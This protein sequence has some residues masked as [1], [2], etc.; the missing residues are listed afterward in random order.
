MA[1]LLFLS[2][3]VILFYNCLFYLLGDY[4]SRFI[5]IKHKTVL[6]FFVFFLGYFLVATPISLFELSWSLFFISILLLHLVLF[7]LGLFYF[8]KNRRYQQINKQKLL[9]YVKKY[10]FVIITIIILIV[11]YL[12]SDRSLLGVAEKERFWIMDNAFYSAKAIKAI[13]SHHIGMMNPENGEMM[14]TATK[15]MIS[16]V[17]WEYLWSFVAV[18][19]GLS[20]VVVSKICFGILLLVIVVLVLSEVFQY[21]FIGKK[22][23][24]GVFC[25]PLLLFALYTTLD[26]HFQ[27]EIAKYFYVPFYGNTITT[28]VGVPVV[29]YCYYKAIENAKFLIGLILLPC[30]FIVFSAGVFII[31]LVLYPLLIMMWLFLKKYPFKFAKT[32]AVTSIFGLLIAN[33]IYIKLQQEVTAVEWVNWM[34]FVQYTIPLVIISILGFLIQQFQ[35]KLKKQEQLLLLV[36]LVLYFVN[37][38]EQTS[39]WIFLNYKFSMRRFLVSIVFFLLMYGVSYV[40]DTIKENKQTVTISTL[41]ALLFTQKMYTPVLIMDREYFHF[42]ENIKNLNRVPEEEMEVSKIINN[43]AKTRDVVNYCYYF[44]DRETESIRIDGNRRILM[45]KDLNTLVDRNVFDITNVGDITGKPWDRK[46]GKGQCNIFIS[47]DPK[48]VRDAELSGGKLLERVYS[49]RT[50]SVIH[51]FVF[52][53]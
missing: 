42:I 32:I 34:V 49:K 9:T 26:G 39:L 23:S 46:G 6:G 1:S 4:F 51:I 14:T 8:L 36:L 16:V 45:G 52:Q 43:F 31:L 48:V 13:G 18:V 12:A 27:S 47:D 24:W 25:V 37:L 17:T 10:C 28:M 41:I 15:L 33:Y 50:K 3:G 29:V 7:C 44:S 40:F 11:F 21:I 53:Y 30:V 20:V 35:H 5:E 2:V 22:Y 38:P 19:T